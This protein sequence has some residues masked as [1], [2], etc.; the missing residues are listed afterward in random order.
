MLHPLI[1]VNRQTRKHRTSSSVFPVITACAR[2]R[3]VCLR[4]VTLNHCGQ[5]STHC[6]R[7]EQAAADFVLGTGTDYFVL[8]CSHGVSSVL[9]MNHG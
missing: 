6:K 8:V 1:G 9:R 7:W 2:S 4:R 3:V 5:E